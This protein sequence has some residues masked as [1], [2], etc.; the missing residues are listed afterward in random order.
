MS[1]NNEFNCE[2]FNIQGTIDFKYF[3]GRGLN[4]TESR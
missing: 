3:L 4:R 2:I 1:N